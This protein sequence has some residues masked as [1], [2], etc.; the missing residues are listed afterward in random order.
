MGHLANSWLPELFLRTWQL[1]EIQLNSNPT[2][3]VAAPTITC[4]K[5]NNQQANGENG[6][7]ISHTLPEK[8]A[9]VQHPPHPPTHIHKGVKTCYTETTEQLHFHWVASHC[10]LKKMQNSHFE[11]LNLF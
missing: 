2:Y 1:T 3:G 6:V 5:F 7:T 11:N 9:I 10:N 4:P 8:S